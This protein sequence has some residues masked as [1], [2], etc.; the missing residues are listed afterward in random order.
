MQ[1]L[2]KVPA[3]ATPPKRRPEPREAPVHQPLVSS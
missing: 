2:T 1:P 3:R